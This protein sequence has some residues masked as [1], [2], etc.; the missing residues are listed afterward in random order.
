[1]VAVFGESPPTPKSYRKRCARCGTTITAFDDHTHCDPCAKEIKGT[2]D[3]IEA[4]ESDN[5]LAAQLGII[6]PPKLAQALGVSEAT[7]QLWRQNGNGPPFVKMGKN[8]LYRVS[9][10]HRW[11]ENNITDRVRERTTTE[12]PPVQYKQQGVWEARATKVNVNS[13][14]ENPIKQ[15]EGSTDER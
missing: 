6:Y 11:L 15:I 7:L 10:V 4:S 3:Q 9:D 14:I 12:V 5:N 8:V 13:I 1:M 2:M